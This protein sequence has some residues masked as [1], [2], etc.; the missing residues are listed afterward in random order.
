MKT[1]ASER[2]ERKTLLD[3]RSNYLEEL[4]S[5]SGTVKSTWDAELGK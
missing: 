2:G 3:L 1:F 5:N 4:R